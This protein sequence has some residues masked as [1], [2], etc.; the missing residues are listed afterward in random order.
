MPSKKQNSFKLKNLKPIESFKVPKGYFEA[1]PEC[2][3]ARIH[4]ENATPEKIPTFLNFTFTQIALAASFVGLAIMTYS[5]IK[6]AVN[7]QNMK[8]TIQQTE[9][10]NLPDNVLYELDETWLY[11]IYSETSVDNN[12]INS[13]EKN[14]TDELINYLI[15]EDSEIEILIQEL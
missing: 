9:I 4:E 12:S 11:D 6:F 13:T 2:I 8:D 15:L 14:D 5:G 3:Q 10:T 7:N 1:F